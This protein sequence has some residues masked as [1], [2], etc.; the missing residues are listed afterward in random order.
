MT[1]RRPTR[2]TRQSGRSR[3]SVLIV[4]VLVAGVGA[5]VGA[6]VLRISGNDSVIGGGSAYSEGVAGTWQRVNP[7]FSSTNEADQDLVQLVYSGLVRL[8]PDGSVLP[9]LADLPQLSDD[10]RT[11]TFK[12]R[13]N[14]SWHDGA[15]VTSRDISFTLNRLTDPDFKGDP[16][17]AEG[18]L[19]VDVETPDDRTVVVHLK[20][21]S[22]PFLARSTT[23]GILPQHLLG[24]LSPAALFEAPFN[25]AP[26]GTGPFKVKSI[27]SRE[28][29]LV[30]NTDYHLGRP[31]L[32]T[33]KLRFYPDYS[34]AV[35]GLTAGEVRGLMVRETLTESQITELRK[36]KGMKTDQP[37]R[38]DYLLLYLN[39]DQAAYFQD[40][41]VRRA[42]SIALDRQAIV[43]RVFFGFAKASSSAIAPGSWAYAKA[44]DRPGPNLAEAR[45][46]LDEAGWKSHPTTGILLKDGG[47]FRFTI[48]TDNDPNRVAV[49]TEIA[50]QLEPLGIRATVA[51]TTFSVLRRD[52]LQE[53]K[54]DA[55][56]TGWSQGPD[57]D[58]YFGWH[59][60]QMGTA[61][62]NL[63]NFADTVSDELIS[64]GRTAN[65]VEVRKD[66]YKQF[67]E[68]W[69]ELSPSVVIAYPQYLYAHT[70]SLGG[71]NLGVLFNGSL[72]FADAYK[73]HE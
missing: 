60:S 15:P 28:A 17:L 35:R 29:V 9:D 56:V 31:G 47:E 38:G 69:D 13:R 22:A 40:E 4:A 23:I 73:W 20:Q 5:A 26:V 7:L 27:D 41:R 55:A 14:L 18:W 1:T 51:S 57:P 34:S 30:A 46:L 10:G 37:Q 19:G 52:F 25:A 53:R 48:R 8:G 61:G 36:A 16:S 11:Y 42:I 39:N 33:I 21:S 62:L 45:K 50:R 64:K 49:A 67:Q 54:Y 12:L 3:R 58:P 63:A 44:Y 72:R 2:V 59:S 68:V 43:E 32:D 70:D 66:A 71:M 6:L 65:D 24:S